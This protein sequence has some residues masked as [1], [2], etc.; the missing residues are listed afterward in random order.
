MPRTEEEEPSQRKQQGEQG[1]LDYFHWLD[2]ALAIITPLGEMIQFTGWGRWF[3]PPGK[4]R[5]V[6]P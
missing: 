3:G 5:P 2:L 1:G 4:R 6:H